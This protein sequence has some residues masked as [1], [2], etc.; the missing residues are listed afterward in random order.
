MNELV[1]KYGD[2]DIDYLDG[3]TARYKNGGSIVARA[4][5]NRC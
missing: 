3:I 2:A 5:P 4:I 1:K